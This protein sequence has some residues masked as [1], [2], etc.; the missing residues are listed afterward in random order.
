MDAHTNS[1]SI[2]VYFCR[3]ATLESGIP[4]ALG[5][6]ELRDDISVEPVP[7]GGRIDPRYL[8]K[9]FESGARAVCVLTCPKSHCRLMEGNLRATHRIELVREL[10]S[11]AGLDPQSIQIFLPDGPGEESLNTAAENM[12]QFVDRQR[13]PVHGVMA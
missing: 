1:A 2:R 9:A 12:A 10:M 13:Q 3:T 8:L 7:C 5:R 11:E 6:L 4:P